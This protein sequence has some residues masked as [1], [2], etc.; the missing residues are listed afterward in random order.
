MMGSVMFGVGV[1]IGAAEGRSSQTASATPT[2]SSS[3]PAPRTTGRCDARGGPGAAAAGAPPRAGGRTVTPRPVRETPGPRGPGWPRP[4]PKLT[5][6]RVRSGDEPRSG[7]ES[8]GG[9]PTTVASPSAGRPMTVASAVPSSRSA[10]SPATSSI[11]PA[12]TWR[13]ILTASRI[14]PASGKRRAG[15]FSSARCTSATRIS[16]TSGTHLRTGSGSWSRT[17]NRTAWMESASKALWE[18][19]SS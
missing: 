2:T 13:A 8:A 9:R 1:G 7:G 16:G 11:S 19:S 14:W 17:W 4:F 3:T 18:V 6:G 15:S 5:G 10:E 12:T